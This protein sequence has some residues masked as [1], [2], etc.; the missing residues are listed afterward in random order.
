MQSSRVTYSN[1]DICYLSFGFLNFMATGETRW[2]PVPL[3]R[4]VSFPFSLVS[5]K[6]T[7]RAHCCVR[8]VTGCVFERR[9][10]MEQEKGCFP[11]KRPALPQPVAAVIGRAWHVPCFEPELLLLFL[12]VACLGNTATPAW[13]V[14]AL[15]WVQGVV[16]GV[17]HGM[18]EFCLPRLGAPAQHPWLLSIRTVVPVPIDRCVV[19]YLE[20]INPRSPIWPWLPLIG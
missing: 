17:L 4:L 6:S 14:V 9:Y 2:S 5:N 10:R 20:W 19:I 18:G 13:L 11:W 7:R 1:Q 3:T 15:F 8:S 12:V 16:L